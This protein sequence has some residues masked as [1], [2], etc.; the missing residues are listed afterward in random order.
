M[1]KIN[2]SQK[3]VYLVGIGIE[4]TEGFE[5]TYRNKITNRAY[6][7]IDDAIKYAVKRINR[8]KRLLKINT[9][10]QINS[11]EEYFK[12]HKAV[13]LQRYE[14]DNALDYGVYIQK[15]KLR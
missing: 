9:T 12:N 7:S 13:L 14:K 15:I 11:L 4:K 1:K 8:I 3:C 6:E 5:V 2:L 10:I